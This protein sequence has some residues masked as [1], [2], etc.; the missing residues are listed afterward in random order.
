MTS[1]IQT[2]FQLSFQ[3]FARSTALEWAEGSLT[4]AELD[5]VSAQLAS[6]LHRVH[7]VR[8]GDHVAL[9]VPR[10]ALLA[11]L[12]L[13][14]VRLGAAFVPL[15]LA[16]PDQRL[17]DILRLVQPRALLVSSSDARCA[18]LGAGL[19][20]EVI[21]IDQGWLR[22]APAACAAS[23]GQ[24]EASES[25]WHAPPEGF[26]FCVMFTSGSTGVPKG[27]MLPGDGLLRLAEAGQCVSLAP[28]QRWAMLASPSFD[29]SLYELWVPWLVGATVVVQDKPLPD[30]ATL[31]AFLV[32]RQISDLFFTTALFNA[33][34]E[35]QLPSLSA[36]SQV[37]I[38]GERAS[39]AHAGL[40]LQAN[41]RSSL[42]NGYG[43]TENSVFTL[44]HRLE[45]QDVQGE[46]G[47]PIGCPVPQT[48]IRLVPVPEVGGEEL[49]AAGAG[50]ALGYLGA[51]ELTQEKFVELDGQ[52]WYRTGDLV[53]QRADGACLYVGRADRQV[54]IQGH[55][56]ELDEVELRLSTCPGLSEAVA[57]VLGETSLERHLVVVY[58]PAQ[59]EADL[60]E[61]IQTHLA[62]FLPPGAMPRRYERR[63]KLP[64]L[65]SG[66]I[67]RK[68]VQA[69]LAQAVSPVEPGLEGPVNLGAWLSEVMSG[70][71]RQP[72]L[73]AHA[74]VVTYRAL[75][76]AS[77]LLADRL[78][79]EGVQAGD[80]IPLIMPRSVALV[81]AM[82]AVWRVGAAYVPVDPFS[83]ASRQGLILQKVQPR[84][85]L[86]M[87]GVLNDHAEHWPTLLV[88]H[89][90]DQAPGAQAQAQVLSPQPWP[91][92]P[93][94]S[95]AYVM[96]TSGSTGEP[97]GVCVSRG[98]LV[99]LLHGQ[100]WAD[101]PS[102]A[103]WLLSTSPAFDISAIEIWGSLLHGACTVILEEQLPSMDR[104]AQCIQGWGITHAQ[105]S[106]TVFNLLVDAH[107]EAF[108][109]LAQ[110]LTGG[111][112]ASAS[113]MRRFLLQ[114]PDVALI[115]C[116][117]PTETTVWSLT[118]RVTLADTHH[119]LG[120]TIGS[121]I[122]GT[123]IRLE[124][125]EPEAASSAPGGQEEGEL[126]IGG[127]GVAQGYLHAPDLTAQR[128]L[129]EAGTRWYRTGDTVRRGPDGVLSYVG[130]N[131]R[132]V[133]IQSQRI[134]LDEVEVVLGGCPGV[135]QVAVWMAPHSDQAEPQLVGVVALAGASQPAVPEVLA[136]ARARLPA[137]AVPV[138][139]QCLPSLPLNS[140][141]K[142][143]RPALKSAWVWPQSDAVQASAPQAPLTE[144]ETRLAAIWQELWPSQLIKK[145]ADFIRLGGTS[146]M[147]LRLAD[148][149]QK[150]LSKLLTPLDI[151]RHTSLVEQAAR[152]STLPDM[153]SVV[154]AAQ[155]DEPA[156][157]DRSYA[158]SRSQR[159]LFEA[160]RLDEQGC[161]YLVHVALL[162]D[163]P[164]DQA[165]WQSAWIAL[166]DRHGL[167]RL[168]V[169]H[170]DGQWQARVAASLPLDFWRDHSV[171]DQVPA[172]LACPSPCLSVI[173]RPMDT[174]QVGVMRVNHWPLADGRA[175][176]VWTL[177]HAVIDEAAIEHALAEL[178][179][180][181]S[182][183]PLQAVRGQPEHMRE[184]EH[185]GL[186]HQA[187]ATQA[188]AL[189]VEMRHL[190][191]PLP[192]PPA[193]GQ[194]L[195]WALPQGVADRLHACADAW[196]C[197]PF[198]ILLAAYG[199]ALQAVFGPAFRH[200]ATPFSK[201]VD[202]DM[203]EPITYCLDVRCLEVGAR[204][205][206]TAASQLARICEQTRRAMGHQWE[207]LEE[208]AL[209]LA[210]EAPEAAALLTQF[211]LTWRLA[212]TRLVP[213]GQSEAQLLRVQ[214]T[215][216]RFA[217]C[218]HVA[219]TR[220]GIECSIEAVQSAH[221]QGVVAAVWRAFVS[222]LSEVCATRP[223]A[224]S[225]AHDA[226]A[227][228]SPASQA[229]RKALAQLWAHWLRVDP[230]TLHDQSH[231]LR[232]GGSSLMAMRMA[233]QLRKD[234][235]LDLDLPA[236]LADPSLG[237]MLAH[238]RAAKT[239]WP[240]HCVCIGEPGAEH[241]VLMVPGRGGHA[242]G[243][244]RIAHAIHEGASGKVSVAVVDLDGLLDGVVGP[245]LWSECMQRLEA[246]MQALGPDR[247]SGIAG[248]S[249]GGLFALEL[250]QRNR[251]AG[252][253]AVWLLDASAP[254]VARRDLVRKVE[255]Q[256]ALTCARWFGG[257]AH[258][259]HSYE[260]DAPAEM[261]RVQ[262]T[263]M[264]FWDQLERAV[265]GIH[266][267]APAASVHL[268]QASATI[269]EG[270]LVWRRETNAFRPAD[271]KS[272]AQ[273][274]LLGQHLDLHRGLALEVGGLIVK[275][276][277]GGIPGLKGCIG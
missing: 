48:D 32:K 38:G 94:E 130:R 42:I 167:L 217:L 215:V 90:I 250:A 92:W 117:G 112:R 2:K 28:G 177:H 186:D 98:N 93:D 10:S 261:A 87:S 120:V 60:A 212:P 173:N 91:V 239:P 191:P 102:G 266:C 50:V 258:A 37:I 54:K 136:H 149:V 216:A 203:L 11:L 68:G 251:A 5:A 108:T 84:L 8:A 1:A 73:E 244:M 71:S 147:A 268:I 156:D 134:E 25:M 114:H 205:G 49:W 118:R 99:S 107:I 103:R 226:P 132:Q 267:P 23:G 168:R 237:R 24:A 190:S 269:H 83:P 63:S 135:Q 40:F 119:P 143:D 57:C 225:Q 227:L 208:V 41:P 7:G 58:Q 29:A 126:L 79:A 47:V 39:P 4:Y 137:A 257:V 189:A 65:S 182:G 82:L 229:H 45:A 224:M 254:R 154:A 155:G 185:Q 161:A 133:K 262:R 183:Q 221:E 242:L 241:L 22:G 34:V 6:H 160:G 192:R 80:L 17:A 195:Q 231:F 16:A 101:M 141:G 220:Q 43:P 273:T 95:L 69:Q 219:Q 248:F 207:P 187:V 206:E 51:P 145:D 204:P 176:L 166:A 193:K 200:V 46:L 159:S 275:D 260:E 59:R 264:A 127:A 75:D 139:L 89:G 61:V 116:Y 125:P 26:P 188:R 128:F 165:A 9:G 76:E 274:R 129:Q 77:H 170:R 163:A 197:S 243:L 15:D 271:F 255:R 122:R 115:N 234:H 27:V 169:A 236:F 247:I 81:V 179:A 124:A 44:F 150:Q 52:R 78:R 3:H 121:P 228:T 109:G 181:L 19:A 213:L 14:L 31:A 30:L 86:S 62:Q 20:G 12:E 210:Q 74:G 277:T 238:S 252:V 66:K 223:E 72:A 144:D 222:H 138:A 202:H 67:D 148:L 265:A 53:R 164:V 97:K 96:F 214:Q 142:I 153:H 171:L 113:H 123:V 110:V 85:V 184:S 18:T 199:A 106:T 151:L 162:L 198:P 201:R 157:G 272:W 253:P 55:R 218:L 131:D 36:L 270:G 276:V 232:L 235:G 178:S 64:T 230:T 194:E 105:F 174:A 140:S 152:L 111:E 249:L 209:R 13:A 259:S 196:G 172:D 263:P 211:G 21:H 104:L 246:L 146:L 88:P 245:D 70:Q 56:I 158:L 180:L 233:A 35:D 100:D 256:L 175:F 240:E 33:M